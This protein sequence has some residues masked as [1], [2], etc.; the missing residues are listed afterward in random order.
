MNLISNICPR[1]DRAYTPQFCHRSRKKVETGVD[2]NNKRLAD[3]VRN[4]RAGTNF[5][6]EIEIGTYFENQSML[7]GYS[8][9]RDRNE[10]PYSPLEIESASTCTATLLG[11]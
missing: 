8:A 5:L 9:L 11:K 6:T 7:R 4:W 10:K 1:Y 2:G 3:S